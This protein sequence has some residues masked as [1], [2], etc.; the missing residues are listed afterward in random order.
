MAKSQVTIPRDSSC[1]VSFK[2]QIEAHLSFSKYRFREVSDDISS[3][4]RPTRLGSVAA[5]LLLRSYSPSPHQLCRTKG[6]DF[7]RLYSRGSLPRSPDSTSSK[8]HLSNL[9]QL[10]YPLTDNSHSQHLL[11]FIGDVGLIN[12]SCIDH[13]E[14]N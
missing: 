2:Y 9:Y 12:A 13:D 14:R 11:I 3:R 8:I 7:T 10:Y 1:S 6:A 5:L 4:S